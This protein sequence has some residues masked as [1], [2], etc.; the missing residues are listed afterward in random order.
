MW[1]ACNTIWHTLIQL[2]FLT[3]TILYQTARY[4]LDTKLRVIA[5]G[6]MSCTG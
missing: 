6:L 5:Y 1:N 2:C 3:I 4:H